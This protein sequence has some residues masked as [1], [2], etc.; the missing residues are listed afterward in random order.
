M[1]KEKMKQEHLDLELKKLNTGGYYQSRKSVSRTYE[2]NGDLT[3]WNPEETQ[4]IKSKKVSHLRHTDI[5][6]VSEDYTDSSADA[7]K[8]ASRFIN[9]GN[10][11]TWDS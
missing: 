11:I 1:T 2:D 3:S 9:N 5:F 6:S 7:S 10:I 8:Y 4:N